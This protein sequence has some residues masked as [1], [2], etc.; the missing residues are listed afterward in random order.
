MVSGGIEL[1]LAVTV[2]VDVPVLVGVPLRA[3]DCEP[4]EVRARPGGN[5]PLLTRN[6]IGVKP[7]VL[8]IFE[9]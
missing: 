5:T 3:A 2:K 8:R 9:L 1:S 7:P 6:E 4:L